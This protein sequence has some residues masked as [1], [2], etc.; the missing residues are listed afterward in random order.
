MA[1]VLACGPEALL[2]HRSAAELWGVVGRRHGDIHVVVPADTPRRQ[3]G[4][5]AHR[6]VGHA[7]DVRG[8]NAGAIRVA[9]IPVTDVVTT[10][11]DLAAGTTT[12]ELEAAVN[13]ASHRDLIGPE[14]L[15]EAIELRSGR[16]GV[17]ALRALL[18][19][20][21]FVL[22]QSKLERLFVPL[23]RAAGLPR[24]ESQQWLGR[25]RVDFHW[26]T[27]GLVVECDSL[28][29]HRTAAKQA[30]DMRRDQAHTLAGRRPLRFSHFQVRHEPRYVTA[31]LRTMVSL[32]S[33]SGPAG[34]A[35]G[36][37]GAGG[38]G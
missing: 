22:T 14:R 12:D 34:G 33:P 2:S 13:E 5:R 25:N 30:A 29:F 20:D 4:V 32:L 6:S 7:R 15:R 24:P 8:G 37:D 38:P 3:R 9:R 17:R 36:G 28:R 26:P 10:L 1:A 16:P 35:P 23:A 27:L 18:D 11:I 19:R 21:T 31:A